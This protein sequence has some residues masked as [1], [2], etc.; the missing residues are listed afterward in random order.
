MICPYPQYIG[1]S[2]D[3][4]VR[5]WAI[6][7]G[8]VSCTQTSYRK[9][10]CKFFAWDAGTAVG[11]IEYDPVLMQYTYNGNVMTIPKISFDG[12]GNIVLDWQNFMAFKWTESGMFVMNYMLIFRFFILFLCIEL[13]SQ[14]SPK[15]CFR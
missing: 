2:L 14:F 13:L 9:V 4:L 5:A 12:N 7:Q 15:I 8:N 1:F 3:V 6:P 10:T 11:E